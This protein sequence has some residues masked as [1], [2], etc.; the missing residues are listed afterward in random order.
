MGVGILSLFQQIFPTQES[1]WGFL[2]CGQILYQLSYL[3]SPFQN[4]P[5]KTK[6]ERFVDQGEGGCNFIPLN[7][8][9]RE[10]MD[11]VAGMD[12]QVS[13]L[14]LQLYLTLCDPTDCSPLGS[15]VHGISQA[16]MLEWV[17]VSFS[18]R[19]SWYRDRIW[20]S[21]IAG[22]LFIDTHANLWHKSS[23]GSSLVVQWFG[24]GDPNAGGPGSIHGQGAVSYMPQLRVHMSQ[25]R[26][27][28][29]RRK[30]KSIWDVDHLSGC[31][32][33]RQVRASFLLFRGGMEPSCSWSH[34]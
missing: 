30:K 11:V 20:V 4:F 12:A 33:L 34:M 10:R 6:E 31:L 8:E 25:L 7:W 5:R 27:W 23:L 18:S 21:W 22:R 3:R 26:P 13:A 2:H 1:N 28:T 17:A 9:N 19:S 15:S 32:S 24:L 14:L 16:G 29:T